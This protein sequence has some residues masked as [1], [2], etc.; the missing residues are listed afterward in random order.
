MHLNF[1]EIS[2]YSIRDENSAIFCPKDETLVIPDVTKLQFFEC[3]NSLPKRFAR[4][5]DPF[6]LKALTVREDI[7]FVDY[8]KDDSLVNK[9]SKPNFLESLAR[10]EPS[11][12]YPNDKEQ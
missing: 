10:S 3:L 11:C 6:Q 9:L 8:D 2:F 12:N 7:I 4:D 5:L 1:I